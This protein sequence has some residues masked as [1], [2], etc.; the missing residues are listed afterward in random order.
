[1]KIDS[2]SEA[3]DR[4]QIKMKKDDEYWLRKPKYRRKAGLESRA[5]RRHY[6]SEELIATTKYQT[7]MPMTFTVEDHDC[8]DYDCND[9]GCNN[10]NLDAFDPDDYKRRVPV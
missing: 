8:D 9:Y 10:Y 3:K 5:H 4:T 6:P 1:M 7:G 2:K